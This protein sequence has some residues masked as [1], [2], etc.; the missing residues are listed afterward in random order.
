[1]AAAAGQ[2]DLYA[3][4]AEQLRVDRPTAKVAVLAAM[5]G[6]TSGTAGQALRGMASAYP[7]AM[8][9]LRSADEAG[10]AGRA[11]TTYGG[12][13]VPAWPLGTDLDEGQLRAASA[14]R[15]RFTRNAV[16]QGAAAEVFKA[17]AATVRQSVAAVDARIVLCLHD[18]LLVEAPAER[19]EEVAGQLVTALE[20]T[21]TRWFSGTRVRFVADVRVVRRWSD[22]KD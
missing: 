19:A 18:E 15:G 6:Q 3:P 22:A 21:A 12:R 11:V 5:Y 8:A 2:A 1:L 4:V 16:I 9:Y 14:A 20:A 10:Q 7:V 13:R 17:W